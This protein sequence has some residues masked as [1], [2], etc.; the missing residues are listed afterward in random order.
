MAKRRHGRGAKFIYYDY[1]KRF[2]SRI[3]MAT[4]QGI[5]AAARELQRLVRMRISTPYPPASRPGKPV[6]WNY[7]ESRQK[8]AAAQDDFG[9]LVAACDLRVLS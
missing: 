5:D 6:A 8:I 9:R 3:E 2:R 4:V 1:S 7:F